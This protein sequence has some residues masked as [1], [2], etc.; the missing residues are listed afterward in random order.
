MKIVY[1][2]NAGHT[3]QYANML[4]EKLNLESIPLKKYKI[5]TE[6]IIFLGWIFASNIQGYKKV[7]NK[8]NIKCTI[9]VGMTP[10]DK[11]DVSEI[12][13]INN[14]YGEFFYLQGGV[15]YTKL[16]GIKKFM[17]KMVAESVIKENKPED[18]ELIDIFLNG[19]NNVKEENLSE[20]IECLN[21]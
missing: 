2:S 17:L 13:K 21:N 9:A 20:I 6:P 16:K 15:D 4:A 1:E 3:E 10:P 12:A 5:D 14:V 18:K 7:R 11:Q 19:G 8:A